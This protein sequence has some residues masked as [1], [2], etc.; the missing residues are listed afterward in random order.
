MGYLSS[1]INV[2]HLLGFI[3]VICISQNR[4]TDKPNVFCWRLLT[5]KSQDPPFSISL[6]MPSLG[7]DESSYA[8]STHPRSHILGWK[9]RGTLAVFILTNLING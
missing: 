1:M 3:K 9:W 2:P 5:A 4:P 6:N 8:L 7:K